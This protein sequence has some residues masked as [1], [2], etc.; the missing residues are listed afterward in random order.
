MSLVQIKWNPT[1]KELRVFGAIAILVSILV[2][3]VLY[4]FKNLDFRWA[5]LILAAGLAI[6]TCCMISKEL[7]RII[8]L[9]LTFITL[10][11]GWTISFVIMSLFYFLLLTPLGLFFRL[12]GRDTLGKKFEPNMKSYWQPHSSPADCE[13]YFRQF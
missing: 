3:L 13:R 2:S 5:A 6:F 8:Y 12:I 1:R 10:P 4:L 7:G 9:A 11:I